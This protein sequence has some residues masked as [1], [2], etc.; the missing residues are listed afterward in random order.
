VP[1]TGG[2]FEVEVDG[3]LRFSKLSLGRFPE[4]GEV[5][6]LLEGT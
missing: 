6:R 3:E 1:S 4:A 5:T 2:A